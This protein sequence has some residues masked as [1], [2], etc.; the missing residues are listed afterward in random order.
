M[1]EQT[2]IDLVAEALR[3]SG[4]EDELIAVGQFYPR[5]HTGGMFAGGMVGSDAG[6]LVGGI[7]GDIGMAA[8]W[9]AGKR[10]ADRASGLPSNMLV[11][12]SANAVY[13]LDAP[14]RRSPP[15]A[16]VFI[17]PRSKLEAKVHQRVNVRV[18]ELID[19]DSGAKIELEGNRLAV[20]HSGDVIKALAG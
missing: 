8:G 1:S 10:A 4:I 20:T 16:I 9:L 13:G 2:M 18:L 19:T 3:A 12:V 7:G 5:G 17:V 14:G 15:R 11:G 6:S